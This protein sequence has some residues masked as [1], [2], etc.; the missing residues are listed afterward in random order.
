MPVE[1]IHSQLLDKYKALCHFT[2]TTYGGVS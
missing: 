1:L 2:T